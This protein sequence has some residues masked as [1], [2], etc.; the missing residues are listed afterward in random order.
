MAGATGGVRDRPGGGPAPRGAGPGRRLG[1]ALGRPE[2]EGGR[3]G[4]ARGEGG[5]LDWFPRD[6]AN[7]IPEGPGSVAR[8]VKR[9]SGGFG[10]LACL[11]AMAFLGLGRLGFS[12]RLASECADHQK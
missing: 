3:E 8:S 2:G 12:A 9:A 6:A 10:D 1:R 11:G 5:I 7:A 4:R